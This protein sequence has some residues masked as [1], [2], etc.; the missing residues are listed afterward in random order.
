MDS[1]QLIQWIVVPISL[2]GNLLVARKKV[3]GFFVWIVSNCMW[4]YVGI[5][6]GLWGMVTL[7]FIYSM[8][9]IYA[10]YFWI[11]KK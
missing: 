3:G 4:I 8:I 1:V 9:N 7:F 2:L 11:S 6:T 10:I 5:F